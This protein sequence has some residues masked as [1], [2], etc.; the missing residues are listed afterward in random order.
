MNYE[1]SFSES[2]FKNLKWCILRWFVT[3]QQPNTEDRDL[4][5]GVTSD[6]TTNIATCKA[7]A[8]EQHL[9]TTK[10]R[11]QNQQLTVLEENVWFYVGPHSQISWG[12]AVTHSWA[13]L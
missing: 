9:R 8:S 4:G 1:S 5:A 13:C 12:T 11:F 3:V 10:G 6:I 2:F 7:H